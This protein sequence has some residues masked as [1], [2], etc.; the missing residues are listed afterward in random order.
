MFKSQTKNVQLVNHLIFRLQRY[1]FFRKYANKFEEKSLNEGYLAILSI[2]PIK[3]SCVTFIRFRYLN[4]PFYEKHRINLIF[5]S[6]YLH[7]SEKS[8]IFAADFY[9]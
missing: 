4:R 2:N 9:K 8:S 5:L 7:I 6:K 1:N 3:Q